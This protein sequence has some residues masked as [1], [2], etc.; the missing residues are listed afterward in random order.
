MLPVVVTKQEEEVTD[1]VV[2]MAS[3]VPTI[4]TELEIPAP[5]TQVGPYAETD[6]AVDTRLPAPPVEHGEYGDAVGTVVSKEL[7]NS[8]TL[9]STK[10]RKRNKFRRSDVHDMGRRRDTLW[11]N[12]ELGCYYSAAIFPSP[13]P[14]IALKLP[15]N[16]TS[17]LFSALSPTV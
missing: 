13:T 7:Y 12:A 14:C 5:A 10:S 1:E 16:G 2:H 3:D 11:N 4:T 6:V 9:Q 15:F 8:S 17:G